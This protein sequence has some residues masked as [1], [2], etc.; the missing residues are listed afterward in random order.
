MSLLV[1]SHVERLDNVSKFH[2][3]EYQ[4]VAGSMSPALLIN[5]VT[6]VKRICNE[7]IAENRFRRC[8][9]SGVITHTVLRC[10]EQKI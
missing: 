6:Q 1:N 4:I 2:D 5:Y 10:A 9:L 3:L 8:E 7:Y